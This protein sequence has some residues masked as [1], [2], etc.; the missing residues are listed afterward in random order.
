MDN[1]R[2]KCEQCGEEIRSIRDDAKFCSDKCRAKA[3]REREKREANLKW[4]GHV[5]RGQHEGDVPPTG[6]GILVEKCR[7]CGR[8]FRRWMDSKLARLSRNEMEGVNWGSAKDLDHKR[9][10]ELMAIRLEEVK[11]CSPECQSVGIVVKPLKRRVEVEEK[12][13]KVEKS[14]VKPAKRRGQK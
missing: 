4:E 8:E 13:E 12:P 2:K 10:Y 14:E 5:I 7:S 9:F 6:A 3:A 1:E 11:F